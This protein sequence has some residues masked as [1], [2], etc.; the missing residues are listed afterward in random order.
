MQQTS[1]WFPWTP[2]KSQQTFYLRQ[3]SQN[4]QHQ[5]ELPSTTMQ[6][7]SPHFSTQPALS[8]GVMQDM[9]LSWL[10]QMPS[11]IPPPPGTL[12]SQRNPAPCYSPYM[13]P[14]FSSKLLSTLPPGINS[15]TVFS[16]PYQFP[17]PFFNPAMSQFTS[18]SLVP[19]T[20]KDGTPTAKV[21]KIE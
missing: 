18:T 3:L 14:W 9:L 2:T 8:N 13:D 4:N 16:L 15:E 19:P 7:I 6:Q 20:I 1:P 17:S 12:L 11:N 5:L 10:S 21:R